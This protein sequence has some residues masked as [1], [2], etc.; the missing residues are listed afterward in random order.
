MARLVPQPGQN[1]SSR[2]DRQCCRRCARS[3]TLDGEASRCGC[4]DQRR[5]C[6]SSYLKDSATLVRNAV[7]LPSSTFTSIFVTSAMRKS[8]KDFAAVSTA[9][10]AA[11]SQDTVLTP[12]T[13]TIV[14]LVFE[15]LG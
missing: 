15:V 10:F 7:T 1:T 8:R 13:S 6:Y 5:T 12:T 3:F 2:G 14:W 11:S 9:R 4:P